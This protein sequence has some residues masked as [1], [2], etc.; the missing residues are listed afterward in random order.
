MKKIILCL[1]VMGSLLGACEKKL[2]QLPISEATTEQFFTSEND[3]IQASNTI[4]N[5]LR[6]YP[7]RQLN[8][9]ETRSDNLYAV[10]DGG[11]RDWEGINSFHRTIASNPYVIEAWATNYNGIFRANLMLSQLQLNGD[12][13]SDANVRTRLEAEARF[14]RAFFYFDLLRWYGRVPLIDKLV[15][16][17]EALEIGRAPVSEVYDL[18]ISDLQ[19]AIDNLP[20]TYPAAEK[21]RVTKNA[22]RGILALVHMT[23]SGPTYD[24]EGPG[25]GVNEWG[26]A[27]TLLNEII[28][29]DKYK[30]LPTY[31]EIFAFNNENNAEVLFDVQY[32]TGFNPVLGATFPWLLVPDDWFR[33][34]GKPV[35]GGLT[36]RPISKDLLNSY[37]AND[38]RKAFTIQN[39]YVYNNVVES[40]SFFVKYVDIDKV[41]VNRIDW[42]INF[43]VLRYTDIIMM[44]AECILH[45]APGTQADVDAIVNQV[46]NRAGLGPVSNVTLPQL[47]EERRKEFAAEGLRWHD[48]VRSGLVETV[49]T[50]WIPAEDVQHQMQPF[51]KNYILY[52]VPQSELDVK[53]GLYTQNQGY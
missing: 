20:E 48:L 30:F 2:D 11:V 38:T 43:I 46:R 8:L 35:Q 4:Y 27:L 1:L 37:E 15:S 5:D 17:P 7:D 9:S 45:G 41:P 12:I 25:L 31:E 47:M 53:P 34:Q 42:S 24:I 10:S 28:A 6:T 21:G 29:S 52:P 18:V 14:L 22:A 32:E 26:Q 36:I 39:G 49:M 51:N 19:F 33:S 50:A 40:R 23:R 44:K 3:F 16:P 13:I